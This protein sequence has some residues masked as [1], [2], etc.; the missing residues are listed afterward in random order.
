MRHTLFIVKLA[1][2]FKIKKN[3]HL[4]QQNITYRKILIQKYP[5][6]V[7]IVW[8][9]GCL[10]DVQAENYYENHYENYDENY[11]ENYGEKLG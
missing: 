11:G 3:E 4:C 9:Q 10:A 2:Q 1:L 5:D 8:D 6:V 7:V